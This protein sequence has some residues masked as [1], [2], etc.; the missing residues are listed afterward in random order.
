MA[1]QSEWREPSKPPCPD[2]NGTGRAGVN[3]KGETIACG[4]CGG[5]GNAALATPLMALAAAHGSLSAWA[6]HN[7]L[8]ALGIGVLVLY[9]LFHHR[10]YRRNRRRGLSVWLSCAGPFGTRISKRVRL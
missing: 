4:T 10:H 3:A 8:W 1:G 2:C 6:A 7:P 5:F 9:A